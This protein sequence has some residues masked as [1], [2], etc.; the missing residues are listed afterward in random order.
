VVEG[1][2]PLKPDNLTF[3][4][5][6]NPAEYPKDEVCFY[7]PSFARRL[8]LLKGDFNYVK[9]FIYFRIRYRGASR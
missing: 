6:P 1:T 7:E 2:G 5:V 3:V 9:D 4:K 8:L